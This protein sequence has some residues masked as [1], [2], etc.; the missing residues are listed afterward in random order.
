MKSINDFWIQKKTL[1]DDIQSILSSKESYPINITVEYVNW[2]IWKSKYT[3]QNF[4]FF[5]I[6]KHDADFKERPFGLKLSTEET[7]TKIIGVSKHAKT[8]GV[9]K[10]M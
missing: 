3:N 2:I 7:C 5:E 8:L 6:Y 4:R 9:E 1:L 10:N